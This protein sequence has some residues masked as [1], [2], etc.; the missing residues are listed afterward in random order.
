MAPCYVDDV[1]VISHV[2]RKTIEGIQKAFKLTGDN[3]KESPWTRKNAQ[4]A[5][6]WTMSPQM[7]ADASARNVEEK[8]AK[9]GLRLPSKCV[10]PMAAKYHPSDDTS[11][12]FNARGLQYYQEQIGVLRWA[13]E[14]GRLD[15]LLEVGLLTTMHRH[16]RED[17]LLG[18]FMY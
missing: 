5:E 13:V 18:K 17:L 1:M 11:P 7:Y 16:T 12:V 9:D 6:C 15:I 8:L 2:P 10:A 14:I 3:A 4:G